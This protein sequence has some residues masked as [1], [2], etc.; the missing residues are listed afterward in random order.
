MYENL[1]ERTWML[2]FLVLRSFH[3]LE[4]PQMT[5][6]SDRDTAIQALEGLIRSLEA[7]MNVIA[8]YPERAI[9]RACGELFA[10]IIMRIDLELIPRIRNGDQPLPGKAC[11]L[12][13]ER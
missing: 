9:R 2:R 6:Q 13:S 5:T 1:H 8:D 12:R 4:V 7:P 11:R 10:D 3:H